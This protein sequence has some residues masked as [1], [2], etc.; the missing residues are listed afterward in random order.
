GLVGEVLN[1]TQSVV[2]GGTTLPY[3]WRLTNG[4]EPIWSW[5]AITYGPATTNVSLSSFGTWPTSSDF[6]RILNPGE[7]WEGDSVQYTADS[8]ALPGQAE[9]YLRAM[10]GRN[11]GDTDFMT[12][13]AHTV[14]VTPVP[15]PATF[16]ALILGVGSLAAKRR[17]RV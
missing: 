5:A 13:D 7:V 9:F 3:R 12:R 2:P 1:P 10:G 16:A 6:N 14:V 4:S 15:E 8:A 17:K 11:I